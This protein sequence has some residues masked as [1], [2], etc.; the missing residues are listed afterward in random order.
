[1]AD[2]F[3][4]HSSRDKSL[5]QEIRA[6]LEADGF[7][8]CVDIDI[9]P[10]VRP[11]RVTAKTAQTLRDAMRGCNALLYLITRHSPSSRWMP[12]EL[13]YFDGFRGRVFIYPV[14]A[15]A[16]RHARGIEYLRIYP[17]VPMRGRRS[18]LLRHVPQQ[19]VIA[20]A[21]AG[22]GVE[23]AMAPPVFDHA[24]ALATVDYGRKLRQ[25]VVE[26]GQMPGALGEI[27][28]AWLRLWGLAPDPKPPGAEEGAWKP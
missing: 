22:A 1:M 15:A 13:G 20:G 6:E 7:S 10:S 17:K 14:D 26:P 8:V 12:W 24:D 23:R 19:R 4:S 5:L 9:L 21:L 18:Y 3:L 27:T 28:T 2:I 11:N 25:A 16:A